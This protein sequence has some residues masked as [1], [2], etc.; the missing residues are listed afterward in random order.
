MTEEQARDRS[1]EATMSRE[2]QLARAFVG[3]AD[4]LS[5]QF[6][7]LHLFHRLVGNCEELLEVDSAA[8]LMADARGVLRTM[9]AS[10]D[11]ANL[12]ELLRLQDGHGPCR[13]SYLTGNHVDIPDVSQDG[14][15]WP[16]FSDAMLDAGYRAVHTVPL[17]LRHR[18]LG[19]V[20]LFHTRSGNVSPD[21]RE[22]AQALADTA[23]LALLH[24]SQEPT[25]QEDILT[26]VQNA[27]AAK[28]TLETA[29]GMIAE[30]AG[31]TIPE[32]AAILR[33]HA[34]RTRSRLSE[35]A[36]ALTARRLT[37]EALLRPDET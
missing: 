32:A 1:R 21:H 6:D 18:T 20:A 26:R 7:P 33:R 25:T 35:T 30:Y 14:D 37:L 8:V 11:E 19:A 28:V 36:Q 29:K 27:I 13:T 24:W 12:L 5:E 3:L 15:R 2:R 22:L 31:T 9:A 23:A 4:T 34:V 10:R 16:V 17:R